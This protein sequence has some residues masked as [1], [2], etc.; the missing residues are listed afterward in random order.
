MGNFNNRSGGRN[1]GNRDFG[2]NRN[3][4]RRPEMHD[5]ICSNCGKECQVPFRPTGEKP[6]YCRDCFAK[7]NPEAGRSFERNDRQ[8]RPFTPRFNDDRRS[9][10]NNNQELS[11]ISIKLDKILMLLEKAQVK[12]EPVIA[13]EPVAVTEPVVVTAPTVAET[14]D[15]SA[16]VKIKKKRTKVAA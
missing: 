11:A 1:F 8:N 15:T 6:V 3:D 16:P 10:T 13:A 12:S 7:M 4:S 2:R 5:A 14:E 9:G